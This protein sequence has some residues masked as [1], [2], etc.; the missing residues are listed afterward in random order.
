MVYP[1]RLSSRKMSCTELFLVVDYSQGL[2][3][4]VHN[5][6]HIVQV[7]HAENELP[8]GRRGGLK[9]VLDL[10][11]ETHTIRLQ[12]HALSGRQAQR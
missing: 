2:G 10:E 7:H 1:V 6:H 4:V 11:Q 8:D 5:Y 12:L 9:Q 3:N